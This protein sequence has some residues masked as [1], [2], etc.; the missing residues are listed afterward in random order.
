MIKR[1]D[2]KPGSIFRV[3]ESLNITSHY[4]ELYPQ[5]KNSI[6]FVNEGECF[7]YL[8]T[9]SNLLFGRI[10]D[11]WLHKDKTIVLLEGARMWIDFGDL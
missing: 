5:Q 4:R 9:F 8:F 10:F 3:K 11:V 6:I 7:F 1:I 2:Y